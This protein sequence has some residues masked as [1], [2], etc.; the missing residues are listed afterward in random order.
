MTARKMSRRTFLKTVGI[1][2][3]G[4]VLAA[5]APAPAAAPETTSAESEPCVGGTLTVAVRNPIGGLDPAKIVG[6]PS[7]PAILYLISNKLV[8]VGTDLKLYPDLA[9]SWEAS[10]DGREWTFH[11]REGVTFHDGTPFTSEAVRAHFEHARE[12]EVAASTSTRFEQITS[13]ETPDDHTVILRTDEPFG[14]FLNYMTAYMRVT[15]SPASYEEY[16][17]KEVGLHPVGAGPYKVVEF[18]PNVSLTLERNEDYYGGRP[19]LDRI[20]VIPVPEASARANLLRTGEVDLAEDIP[21]EEMA[22]LDADPNINVLQKKSL[23]HHG[24]G[25]NHDRPLFQ[26]LRVRHAFNYAIDKATIVDAVFG[27]AA[28]ALDSPLAPGMIGYKSIGVYTHDPEKAMALLAEAG[29]EDSDGDGVLDK[30]GEPLQLTYIYVETALKAGEVAQALQ[31]DLKKIGVDLQLRAIEPAAWGQ[32]VAPERGEMDADLFLISFNPSAG[33]STRY[34]TFDF[35][36]NPEPTGLPYEGNYGWYY[37][38]EVD[39]LL[40]EAWLDVDQQSRAQ[41]LEGVQELL[42]EDAP[43]IWLYAP[44]LLVGTR[45]DVEGADVYPMSF[46]HLSEARKC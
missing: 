33:S 9:E 23:Y 18:K 27:G 7:G 26:D 5:C 12:P 39:E 46:L 2:T 34:L 3:G 43:W 10:S 41:K 6:Y 13:I 14:P 20:V 16:E 31:S 38:T 11:L 15:M 22:S 29:W 19:P 45:A 37:N 24:V 35:R 8:R 25:F 4:L 28:T 40:A 21:A 42:W 32:T 44:D 17:P 30:D 1:A 36:S